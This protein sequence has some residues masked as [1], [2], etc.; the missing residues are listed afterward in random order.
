MTL[1]FLQNKPI[2]LTQEKSSEPRERRRTRRRDEDGASKE[3][4]PKVKDSSDKSR[5]QSRPKNKKEEKSESKSTHNKSSKR[6]VNW[7]QSCFANLVVF[8]STKKSPNKT[9][10]PS[11]TEKHGSKDIKKHK[12]TP[13]KLA[14]KKSHNIATNDSIESGIDDEEHAGS[15]PAPN[16]TTQRAS[17]PYPEKDRESLDDQEVGLDHGSLLGKVFEFRTKSVDAHQTWKM[18]F[19]RD[20][21]QILSRQRTL[22]LKL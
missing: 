18:T 13:K 14:T 8:Q 7:A 15:S 10:K 1:L 17:T 12:K 20:L 2:Q 5:S 9:S 6:K 4:K 11:S 3:K 22:G 21:T 16:P 19:L